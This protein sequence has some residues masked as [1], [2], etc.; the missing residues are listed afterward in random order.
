MEQYTTEAL[1][2]AR[3]PLLSLISKSKKAQQKLKPETW[4]YKMLADNLRAL[5]LGLALVDGG[6]EEVLSV[7][8]ADKEVAL[9]A[10]AAM[11]ARTEGIHPKFAAGTAQHTLLQNRLFALHLVQ[12]LINQ[13]G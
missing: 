11:I 7:S 3:P 10:C 1:A 8:Q 9:A 2:R 12:D 6:H 13:I 4:Q 5:Q